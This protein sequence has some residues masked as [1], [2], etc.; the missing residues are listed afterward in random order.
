M[1][2]PVQISFHGL[3]PSGAIENLIHEQA[4]KLARFYQRIISCRVVIELPNRHHRR[5]NVFQIRIFL[6]VPGEEIVVARQPAKQ[7]GGENIQIAIRNAFSNATRLLRDFARRQRGDVKLHNGNPHA[8]VIRYF[9]NESCGFLLTRDGREVYFHERS[10]LN[11]E[12]QDLKLGSEV[13]FTEEA[14]EKG[15]QATTVELVG[16]RSNAKFVHDFNK[17]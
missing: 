9:P 10:V 6:I 12:F 8:T 4:S 14:G 13:R 16:S 11:D 3:A 1:D 7:E 5:G 17:L 2:F 15:P